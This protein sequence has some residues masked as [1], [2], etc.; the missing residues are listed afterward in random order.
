VGKNVLLGYAC[1]IAGLSEIDRLH[2]FSF[3]SVLD[4]HVFV[5]LLSSMEKHLINDSVVCQKE[6]TSDHTPPPQ[7]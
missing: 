1:A 7:N 6:V 4:W 5:S 3:S 2:A